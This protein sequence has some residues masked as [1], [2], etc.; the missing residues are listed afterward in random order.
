LEIGLEALCQDVNRPSRV[1]WIRHSLH[2]KTSTVVKQIVHPD[3][4]QAGSQ[5][6]AQAL[7]RGH[8]FVGW[9]ATGRFSEFDADGNLLFDATVPPTGASHRGRLAR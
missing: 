3:E 1:V 7:D 4:I 6:N 2:D 9:G 8:T 5:G